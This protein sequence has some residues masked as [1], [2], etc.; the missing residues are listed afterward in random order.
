MYVYLV[1]L[2]SVASIVIVGILV[3]FV[4]VSINALIFI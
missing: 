2:D 3:S 4:R 1:V